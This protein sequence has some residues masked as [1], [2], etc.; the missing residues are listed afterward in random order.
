MEGFVM[1]TLIS[2]GLEMYIKEH[3]DVL[4]SYRITLPE[5]GRSRFCLTV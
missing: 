2:D 5:C 4:A 1:A 3:N